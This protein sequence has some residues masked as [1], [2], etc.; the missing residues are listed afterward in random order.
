MHFVFDDI[1]NTEWHE[2]L[3][4]H[5]CANCYSIVSN[6]RPSVNRFFALVD[7]S[8][9]RPVYGYVACSTAA[10]NHKQQA[11][12]NLPLLICQFRFRNRRV[13]ECDS[14]ILW[15]RFF[16]WSFVLSDIVGNQTTSRSRLGEIIG[17]LLR[18]KIFQ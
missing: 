4:T 2:I 11:F 14:E 10:G 7:I 16:K 9:R 13:L 8:I 1:R 12:K 17:T 6:I 15:G 3:S 18:F 5:F